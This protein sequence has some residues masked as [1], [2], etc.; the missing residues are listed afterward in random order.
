VI[1]A[2]LLVRS[3]VYLVG[4]TQVLANAGIKVVATRAD[5]RDQIAWLADAVILDVDMLDTEDRLSHIA[6]AARSC[7]VLVLENGDG[8]AQADYF[9]AGASAVVGKQES[10]ERI[11]SAVRAVTVTAPF[12]TGQP[13]PRPV[14][15]PGDPAAPPVAQLSEREQQVLRQISMGLTHSQI[16]TRLGISSHTVDTYVKRIRSKLGVGNKAELTRVALLGR[17]AEERTGRVRTGETP[18]LKLVA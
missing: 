10:A 12:Q 4:L 3:P 7:A 9:G 17:V 13:A 5:H 16:A 6:E 11:V 1:R 18:A 8:P 14:D 2:D 15:E